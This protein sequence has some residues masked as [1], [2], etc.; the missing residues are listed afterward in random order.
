MCREGLSQSKQLPLDLLGGFPEERHPSACVHT[1][2]T[3]TMSM[4][5]HPHCTGQ[6]IHTDNIYTSGSRL[7][8]D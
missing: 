8:N 5:A 3:H 2:Q 1:D 6:D 7:L 4:Y